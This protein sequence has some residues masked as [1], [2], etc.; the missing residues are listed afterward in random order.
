[1]RFLFRL[2]PFL[3]GIFTLLFFVAIGIAPDNIPV[4][5]GIMLLIVAYGLFELL[6]RRIR[7]RDFW[8][9]FVL[10]ALFL[11]SGVVFFIL[12]E[13]W[14]ESV[15]V[16]LVVS[17]FVTLFTEQLYRWFYSTDRVPSH[18]LHV[19]I[20]I[21]ELFLVFFISAD[22]FGVRIFLHQPM[23]ALSLIFVLVAF[24]L[25][26]FARWAR[27]SVKPLLI[28]ALLLAIFFGQLFYALLL[29]PTGFMVGGAVVAIVWYV[30]VGLLRIVELGLPLRT[31]VR[32]YS[33]FAGILLSII[34]ITAR[35]I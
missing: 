6:G 7:E 9:S 22:L 19:I 23:W 31:T 12:L 1:M 18:S 4:L 10:L 17:A 11:I 2:I 32:R 33:F 27:G 16:A 25:Y 8:G 30:I 20:S 3:L 24:L 5:G 26:P 15:A 34:A 29:L 28:P 21:L 13:G 35:W 14:F